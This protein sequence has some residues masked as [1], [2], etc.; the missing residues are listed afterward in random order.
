M[1]RKRVWSTTIQQVVQELAARKEERRRNAREQ[2]VEVFQLSAESS[3]DEF[4]DHSL[5][6]SSLIVADETCREIEIVER[7][8][9]EILANGGGE[10][11]SIGL[12]SIVEINDNR[13]GKRTI[14]CVSA[15]GGT[16]INLSD[17]A[18][19]RVVTL[20]SDRS[21]IGGCI[22]GKRAGETFTVPGN[23]LQV[24]IERVINSD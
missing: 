2:R 7:D 22:F 19:S 13:C 18:A 12:G 10:I 20:M 14:L 17:D 21:P 24:K 15:Y 3:E 8:L 6:L 16:D 5:P 1:A 23:G 11:G 9:L 4:V